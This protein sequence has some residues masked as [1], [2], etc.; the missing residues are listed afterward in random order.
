M[1]VFQCHI[2]NIEDS[3]NAHQRKLRAC[4]CDDCCCVLTTNQHIPPH[5]QNM[6]F[7]FQPYLVGIT[8]AI[9]GIAAE[10]D[11]RRERLGKDIADGVDGALQ[12]TITTV[13]P[14]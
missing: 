2:A 5:L 4:L 6:F 11:Y 14:R 13:E 10:Q 12:V 7:L 3:W 9:A 1:L 8:W